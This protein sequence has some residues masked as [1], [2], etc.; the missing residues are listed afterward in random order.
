MGLNGNLQNCE[1]MHRKASECIE[2]HKKHAGMHRLALK[3]Q[4]PV[5]CMCMYRIAWEFIKL[6]GN[7]WETRE[8]TERGWEYIRMY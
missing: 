5:K 7:A 2:M 4:K 8:L 1:E 6:H 3:L